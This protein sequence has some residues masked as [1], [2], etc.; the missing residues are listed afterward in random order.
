MAERTPRRHICDTR[1]LPCSALSGGARGRS[2]PWL[3][4]TRSRFYELIWCG[5]LAIDC[6]LRTMACAPTLAS[7]RSNSAW[8][9]RCCMRRF[10]RTVAK[11]RAL[12]AFRPDCAA[13][14]S[15]L[16]GLRLGITWLIQAYCLKLLVDSSLSTSMS[17][18]NCLT[19]LF[20]LL[21][22]KSFYCAVARATPRVTCCGKLFRGRVCVCTSTV[23]IVLKELLQRGGIAS[24][25]LLG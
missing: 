22:A 12:H 13:G 23:N 24:A 25:A 10:A 2:L 18:S 17:N 8:A 20:T 16:L 6:L 7:C 1:M 4:S 5:M 14:A 3:M 19:C 11:Y 9:I 15:N 21:I